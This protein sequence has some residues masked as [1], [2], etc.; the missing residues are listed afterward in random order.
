MAEMFHTDSTTLLIGNAFPSS[1]I[2]TEVHIRPIDCDEA[3]RLLTGASKLISYWGHANTQA[4]ASLL[5]GCDLA[6]KTSRPALMLDA[7]NH[8]G[9]A[10]H[11]TS[12]ALIISPDFS[13]GYRPQIGEEPTLAQISHWQFLHYIF[14]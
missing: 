7:K 9:L 8:P 1:L 11:H 10:G 6:P 2:R 3:R 12:S 5:L 14:H 4:A 13:T